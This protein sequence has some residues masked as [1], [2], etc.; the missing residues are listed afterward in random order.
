MALT[1]IAIIDDC[2][3]QS[4]CTFSMD[5]DSALKKKKMK[6]PLYKNMDW[7]W[8]DRAKWKLSRCERQLPDVFTHMWTKNDQSKQNDK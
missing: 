8:D 3:K 2:L 5:Y 6:L 7:P 4:W 1:E